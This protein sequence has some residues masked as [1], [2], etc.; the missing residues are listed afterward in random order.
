MPATLC[1]ICTG[2]FASGHRLEQE[3]PHHGSPDDF[4]TAARN[5]CYIC[6]NITTSP[7]WKSVTAQQPYQPAVSYLCPLRGSPPGWLRLNIECL[8]DE[9]EGESNLGSESELGSVS[10]GAVDL[11]P[12][13]SPAWGFVLQPV[14][15]KDIRYVTNVDMLFVY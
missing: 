5:G 11:H 7:G 13:Q 9:V 14:D 12:P 10:D 2:I 4:L 15:G 8:A 1:A 3:Q 6:R